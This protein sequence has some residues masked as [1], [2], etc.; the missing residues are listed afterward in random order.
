MSGYDLV[1]VGGG[2][3]GSTLAK[4]MAERGARVLVLERET[5]FKDRV[6]GEQMHP[7][8]VA[9][10][11]ELGIYGL[12]RASCGHELPWWDSYAGPAQTMHRFLPDTTPQR[13]GEFA[14]Y[15]PAMQEVL[16]HAAT[17][18][19]A[20]VRRG[21]VV[22]EVRPGERPSAVFEANGRVEEARARLVVGADGRTSTTRKWGGFAVRRDPERLLVAGLLFDD[23]PASEDTS[24]TQYHAALGQR[25]LLFPQG[26]GRVRAYL[27]YQNGTGRRLQGD[28]GI[29]QFVAESLRTGAPAEF[30]ASAC[31]AGPLATFEGADTWVGHPYRDGVALIG[32]AAASNDPS[33]GQGLSLTVRDVRVLRD[34]LLGDNNWDA[35]GHAYAAAHDRDYD[36]MHQVTRWCS[37]LFYAM[38]PEAE[39]RRARVL[40]MLAQDRSRMPDHLFC[41]PDLPVDEMTRRRFLG[42]E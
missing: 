34:M 4:A 33:Y 9:E 25:V 6:R 30:Y 2:L 8:G 31:A 11:R 42:E 40:P 3:G 17:D 21:A 13:A 15:H 35:A 39:A 10:A 41:G 38:G 7:W 23:M 32:D 19:G 14:F 27:I 22:R 20:E 24:Y 16:S 1:I 36:A 26:N 28:P 37:D 5:R 18:A 29:P 12:L